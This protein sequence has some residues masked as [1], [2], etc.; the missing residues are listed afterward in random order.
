MLEEFCEH[1]LLHWLEALSLLGCVSGAIEALQLVQG[2][3]KVNI[4]EPLRIT[5]Q[6]HDTNIGSLVARDEGSV[7]AVRL[8]ARR[9]RILPRHQHIV[10]TYVLNRRPLRPAGLPSSSSC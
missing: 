6:S 2:F 10:H 5:H 1:H 3:L 9:P 4:L 8:R 7:A